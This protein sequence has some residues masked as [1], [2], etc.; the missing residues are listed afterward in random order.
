MV[1]EAASAAVC[2]LLIIRVS[3]KFLA[4]LK[5]LRLVPIDVFWFARPGIPLTSSQ[6]SNLPRVLLLPGLNLKWLI[7]PGSLRWSPRS[8]LNLFFHLSTCRLF[9]NRVMVLSLYFVSRSAGLLDGLLIQRSKDHDG[10]FLMTIIRLFPFFF[11]FH[12]HVFNFPGYR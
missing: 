2:D 8:G 3:P 1:W 6:L 5:I 11:W 9:C 12:G 4:F 7:Q 10:S